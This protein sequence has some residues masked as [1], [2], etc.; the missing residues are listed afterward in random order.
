MSKK[1]SRSKSKVILAV[2]SLVIISPF[3]LLAFVILTTYLYNYLAKPNINDFKAVYDKVEP[4]TSTYDLKKSVDENTPI[5]YWFCSLDSS[6]N[7]PRLV[8]SFSLPRL[9][10][11]ETIDETSKILV[12]DGFKEVT[13]PD[14]ERLCQLRETQ[15]DQ[16]AEGIYGSKCERDFYKDSTKVKIF[17]EDNSYEGKETDDAMLEYQVWVYN[18]SNT[19]F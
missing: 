14:S 13:Y 10:L 1:A 12:S 17:T 18:S 11:I 7:R 19:N 15:A 16:F 2:V 8:R 5:V 6:C 9:N 4:V 3:I